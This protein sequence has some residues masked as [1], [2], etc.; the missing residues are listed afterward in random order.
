MSDV[1]DDSDVDDEK[2]VAAVKIPKGIESVFLTGARA[3]KRRPLAR[4]NDARATSD[5][6]TMPKFVLPSLT[7]PPPHPLLIPPAE[8]MGIVGIQDMGP[9]LLLSA[10]AKEVIQADIKFRGAVSDFHGVAK[11][12]KKADCDPITLRYNAEDIYGDG[13]NFLIATAKK[14]V[15]KWEEWA[16]ETKAAAIAAAIAEKEAEE[17]AAAAKPGRKKKPKPV[18]KPWESLGSEVEIEEESIRPSGEAPT[19]IDV[20]R[21]PEEFGRPFKFDDADANELFN[22]SQMECRPYKDTTVEYTTHLTKGTQAIPVTVDGGAQA[23]PLPGK[24]FATQ[25]E[26]RTCTDEEAAEQLKDPALGAFLMDVTSKD[27]LMTYAMQQNECYDIF[28]DDFA[29]LADEDSTIG[30]GGAAD[31]IVEQHAFT[32]LTYGKGKCVSCVDWVPNKIGEVAVACVENASFE[33]KVEASGQTRTGAVLIWN[34]KDPIHPRYVLEAPVD[35]YSFAFNPVNPNLVV[36]GLLNGQ[37]VLWDTTTAEERAD[38]NSKRTDG[39]GGG[40]KSIPTCQPTWLSELADSHVLAVTDVAWMGGN[41]EVTKPNGALDLKKTNECNFFAST[42]ADGKLFFWD[43]RVKRDPKKN[44]FLWYPLY[45][46]NVGRGESSGTL[47]AMKFNF[48]DTTAGKSDCFMTSTD[49]EVALV[50]FV[51]PEGENNPEYVKLCV[52][53]HAGPVRSIDRSPFFPDV[54]L[55]V[56]DW[57]FKLLKANEKTPLFSSPS[58]DVYLACGAFSP[59]RPAVVFTA[60]QDGVVDVW[61]FTD[62]SHEPSVK[63]RVNSGGVGAMK[64][65]RPFP[66]AGKTEQLLA[67]G[68]ASG[69]LHVMSIPRNLRRAL[70][71]EKSTMETFLSREMERIGDVQTRAEEIEQAVREAEAAAE[72]AA[73]EAAIEEEKKKAKKGKKGDPPPLTEDEKLEEEYR[74]LEE[75]FMVEMGLVETEGDGD[76]D[77]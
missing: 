35:V 4:E 41:V 33:E 63:V 9:D 43:I 40:E 11:A 22:S 77:A 13:H 69:V 15:P 64:F 44:K 48:G 7:P 27:G 34:F 68:D 36:G 2:K 23:T 20:Y 76:E 53:A 46:I 72:A 75:K 55:S 50:D 30:G 25:Y 24:P 54:V 5:L 3:S 74:A 49:G 32:D 59:T 8:T 29:A 21:S 56:G 10:V 42:A 60:R 37:C 58:S 14:H 66:L 62:R 16:E 19:V 65:W 6:T 45:K 61:D 31:Q 47:G 38:A 12:I 39:D 1:E 28:T 17:A 70:P 18:S 26:P 67:V 73:E 51:K 71:K 52:T 57:S